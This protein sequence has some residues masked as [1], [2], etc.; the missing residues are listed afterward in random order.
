MFFMHVNYA[1]YRVEKIILASNRPSAK[2][3]PG[4]TF[5]TEREEVHIHERT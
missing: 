3:T 2:K 5:C 4:E 1:E